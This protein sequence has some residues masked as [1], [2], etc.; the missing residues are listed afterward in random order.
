MEQSLIFAHQRGVLHHSAYLA[1][2]LYEL[3]L[4][5][6]PPVL[7]WAQDEVYLL[8]YGYLGGFLVG[9]V[10]VPGEDSPLIDLTLHELG[11][12]EETSH[13]GEEEVSWKFAF[14]GSVDPDKDYF[15]L[16]KDQ[17]GYPFSNG[18]LLFA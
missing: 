8:G 7:E 2:H 1:A 14:L 15:Q 11:I 16:G 4:R 18:S 3:S 9:V 13:E 5:Q 12:A 10:P 17:S 6:I